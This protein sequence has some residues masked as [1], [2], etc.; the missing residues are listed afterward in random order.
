MNRRLLIVIALLIAAG[1]CITLAKPQPVLLDRPLSDFPV[2]VGEWTMAR[3]TSFSQ[4]ILDVLRPTDYLS[5]NYIDGAGNEVTMYIGYHGGRKGD[6]GIHSPRNCLPGSGWFLDSTKIIGTRVDDGG[7]ID[8][9][10]TVM[11]K[12]S[13]T[14]SFY[15][16]FQVKGRVINDEYSLKIAEVWNAISSQR[17]DAAFIRLSMPISRGEGG[18]IDALDRFVRDFYPVIRDYLPK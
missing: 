4:A 15:Y 2:V 1:A 3:N 10:N 12:G 18:R 6:G 14:L 8:I 9:V 17:K 11:S 7:T 16:W 5:R 13:T